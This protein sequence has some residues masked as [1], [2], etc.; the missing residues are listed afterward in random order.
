MASYLVTG[1]AGFIGSHIVER[2]I[3][4]N[5]TVRVADD[6]SSGLRENIPAGID[7]V[8]GDLADPAIAARAVSGMEFVIHQAAIPSVPRLRLRVRRE[9]MARPKS[10]GRSLEPASNAGPRGMIVSP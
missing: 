9:R 1:G 5:N 6:F 2:L 10:P 3:S 4:Q 8:D 7:V